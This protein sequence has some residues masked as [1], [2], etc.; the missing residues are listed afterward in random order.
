MSLVE[1]QFAAL[2]A[3]ARCTEATLQRN[4]DG[5][6][7]VAIP[8]FQL[9]PGWSRR[10]T[11]VY[12]VV[13]LGYPVARPDAFWTDPDL[14]LSTGAPP[15]STGTQGAPGIPSNLKWFSWHPQDW[16]PNS[17]TLQSY[18]GVIRKRFLVL[19]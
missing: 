8:N 7:V 6:Y 1:Q 2:K 14:M 18:V 5:S 10:Y 4:P 9:P 12:F 17:D 3:D 16:R 13:P 11:T 15:Q 19:R